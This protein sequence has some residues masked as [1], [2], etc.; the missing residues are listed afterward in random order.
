MLP[1]VGD[2]DGIVRRGIQ[3]TSG[4]ARLEPDAVTFVTVL[5]LSTLFF[6]LS[7]AF[8]ILRYEGVDI[9]KAGFEDLHEYTT[10]FHCRSELIYGHESRVRQIRP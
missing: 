1:V 10:G 2:C 6:H 7:T 3:H 8:A 9:A 5:A 4:A